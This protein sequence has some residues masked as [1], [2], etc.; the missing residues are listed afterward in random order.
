[1]KATERPLSVGQIAAFAAPAVPISALGLPL[2]VYLPPFYAEQMGIGLATVGTIF[3][4]TRFWDV[5]TDPV[6]GVASDKFRTR[7]GRRRHWMALSVPMLMWCVYKVFMPPEGAGAAYLLLWMILLYIGWTLLTISHISWGAE[8]S[9]QYHERSRI[10]GW[11]EF[12]LVFGMFSVLTLPAI[13]ERG[14]GGGGHAKVASM[15][16]FIVVLLPLTVALALWRVPERPVLDT[17]ALGW[18]RATLL[19]FK[20]VFMRRVL[21]ADLL[22]GI[23]PGITGALY[24]FFVAHVLKMPKQTSLLLLVYFIA[25]FAGI[26]FWMRVSYRLGKHRTLAVAMFYSCFMLALA[27]FWRPGDFWL[28]MAGNVLYGF[29]YGAG[30]FLLRSITADITDADHVECGSQRTGLFYSLLTMTNKVGYALA[31][32][33]TYPLLSLIGFDPTIQNTVEATE[34]LRWI[35]VVL[36]ILF[37][38]AAGLV[39]WSFP[40]DEQRQAALRRELEAREGRVERQA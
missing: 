28:F 16:W 23:G 17:P 6:L 1:M 4:L 10:Q 13:I 35:F 9:G 40:L 18:K 19:I 14:T 32:G 15:G 20:N 25:G 39:M 26:P 27:L 30:P 29:A 11:R 36:P 33:I 12:A 5:I 2:V 21:I 31:V 7:F 38:A 3:M 22:V 34:R 37:M 24:V 8:L